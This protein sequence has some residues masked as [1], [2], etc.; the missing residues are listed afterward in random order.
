MPLSTVEK[1]LA[2]NLDPLRYGTFAEI[3]AG[4]EVVRWF[5]QAGGAAGTIAKSISAYDMKVSDA[6]YGECRRYVS[7]E[8]LEA[9][10][11]LEQG[12][13]RQRL[14]EPRGSTTGFFTFADT[15]SAR[16]YH[17]T[18]NCHAWLGLVF[19]HEPHADDS[20]LTLHVRLLD[21]TN[22][23][24]Q[25]ALGVVGVNLIY[26]AFNHADDPRQ[27]L[28]SLSDNLSPG[29]IEIDL[30]DARGPAFADVDNRI[31]SL[32][33]VE[34]GLTGAALFT[35]D[36]TVVQSA[37]VLRKRPLLLQRGRFRPITHVNVDLLNSA[38]ATFCASPSVDP[39]S[40]VPIMEMSMHDL[41]LDDEV[42]VADFISRA[43]VVA[44]T[45]CTV[46]ISDFREYHRLARFLVSQ[47]NQ[48]IGLAMGLE[49][50][51]R[52]FDES[53]YEDLDG[54]LLESFG[55]LFRNQL[56]LLVYPLLDSATG[57]L[58][59][60]DDLQLPTGHQHL[61]EFLRERGRVHAIKD[62]AEE[63]LNIHS[64]DVLA[65]IRTGDERWVECVP[66]AVAARIV[67]KRLF[68]YQ[69]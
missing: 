68:G 28:K 9:M 65:M 37:E 23:E 14:A 33:L 10:L 24:Q 47:T 60:L 4:Q 46:M 3:G 7:R 44:T 50:F 36:G 49:T 63:H 38:N 27:L 59:T 11:D 32:H 53:F 31:L 12:L 18:N 48:P 40:V 57:R 22:A 5:F 6:V 67:E 17:G 62:V 16:N 25:H 54:G 45:G 43:E 69:R 30:V 1:A 58:R 61:L 35:A 55:R 13:N 39:G 52:L 26:A 56:R 64:P 19:Q 29:R 20:R 66:D 42:C 51:A 2:V 8:R 34:L 15:V 41:A 21:D